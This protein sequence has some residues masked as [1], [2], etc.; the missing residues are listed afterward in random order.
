MTAALPAVPRWRRPGFVLGTALLLLT[1]EIAVVSLAVLRSGHLDVLR[2]GLAADAVLLTGL[3]LVLAGGP[4]A[5]GLTPGKA[6]R[7]AVLGAVP[8]SAA[9]RLLGF[10]LGGGL[11]AVAG[12]AELALLGYVVAVV[13]R[14]A[15][16]P[17]DA[18]ERAQA[19]LAAVLP[20]PIS[21]AL[22]MELR[23]V[24]AALQSLLRRPV[25]G[26]TASEEVFRPM[27]A[28]RAGWVVAFLLIATTVELPAVH[29]VLYVVAPGRAWPHVL[30]AGFNL[31]GLLWVVGERRLMWT[32]AHRFEA[33]A[34]VL[35]LGLRFEARVP[36]E[37]VSRALPLRDDLERRAVQ[38][39]G[40]KRNPR[41][42]PIDPP[43][44][45]L[46]LARPVPFTTFF[47]LT[48]QAQHLDLFMDR[49]EVFLATLEK[50]RAGA[51]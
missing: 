32:S 30:L 13:A 7:A 22:L 37:V 20:A 23:L 11:L 42:T 27:E 26:P 9:S 4:R 17:G 38:P 18:W 2:F 8:F 3:A 31:Y 14:T 33:D 29:V 47:G 15:R 19:G 40:G 5:L 34:L 50:R 39:P 10:S 44:V 21:C 36:Y 43:N 6:L 51:A 48:R 46:C 28:S 41:V 16:Q 12:F 24:H 35:R 49:P 25:S 45:H 1:S